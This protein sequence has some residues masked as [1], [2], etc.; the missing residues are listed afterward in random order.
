[1]SMLDERTLENEGSPAARAAVIARSLAD[2][3]HR[4]IAF[5]AAYLAVRPVAGADVGPV[6]RQLVQCRRRPDLAPTH[7][8]RLAAIVQ[9]ACAIAEGHRAPLTVHCGA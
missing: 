6:I 5:L 7:L 2:E 8:R 3:R 1:M 9:L 4:T